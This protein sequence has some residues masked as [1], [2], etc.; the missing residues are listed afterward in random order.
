MGNMKEK[1]KSVSVELFF[2]KGYFATSISEI[3]RGSGIQ[4]S[5]I[6]YH[7]A[8]KEELLFSILKTTMD[9]LTA[10]LKESLSG[11]RDLESRMRAAI[12]SHVRFHLE[13]QK[14]TF[15]ANSELRGL[16]SEHYRAIVK[17]RDEYENIFQDLIREGGDLGVFSEGDVKI[18]S[19]AILTLCTAGASWFNPSGRLTPDEIS[20]I[21][22][23]FIISGLRQNRNR[24]EA[25]LVKTAVNNETPYFQG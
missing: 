9:D 25:A 5:S 13:R 10:Y 20:V 17:K 15:I 4:K 16:T 1:I 21:Y 18:L 19:Y 6:Y 11:V 24:S 23:N 3:A 12:S 2:K 14:E 8:S 7:Y 22:E